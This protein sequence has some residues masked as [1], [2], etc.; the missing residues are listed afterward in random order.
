M[1]HQQLVSNH[2]YSSKAGEPDLV[3]STS[4]FE[5]SEGD[6]QSIELAGDER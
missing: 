5:F 2:L 1:I 3:S 6:P 4:K